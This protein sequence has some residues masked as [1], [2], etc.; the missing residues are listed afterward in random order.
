[1]GVTASGRSEPP[2]AGLATFDQVLPFQCSISGTQVP[3]AL[4]QADPTAQTLSIE[5][6]P[7]ADRKLALPATF[8]LAALDQ[9]VPFQCMISV[10]SV[11][12]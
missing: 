11:A 3:V 4:A 7:T 6:A 5:E 1:M 9:A 10:V 2:G 12:H 8:G